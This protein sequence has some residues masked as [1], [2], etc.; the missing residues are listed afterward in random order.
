[1]NSKTFVGL[2]REGLLVFV[3]WLGLH[4][5]ENPLA[6]VAGEE[7]VAAGGF[8][9]FA[10]TVVG[11]EADDPIGDAAGLVEVVGDEDDGAGGFH[12]E[13][14][15][16]DGFAGAG[17]E[18]AGGFVHEDDFWI[19]REGACEAEALLLAD[20]EAQGGVVETVFDFVP[21]GGIAE[22]FFE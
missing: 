8:E 1:M 4:F 11:A 12:G 13:D 15:F 3:F 22:G 20:G 7:G 21:E 17:V 5:L 16:F 2:W 9:E 18:G 6:S 14:A 19:E 10:V